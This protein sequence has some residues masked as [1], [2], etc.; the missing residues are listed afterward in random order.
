LTVEAPAALIGGDRNTLE[1]TTGARFPEPLT[2]PQEIADAL[3][4]MRDALLADPASG[5]WGPFLIV[6]RSTGEAAGSAGFMVRPDDAGTIVL[7][8]SVYPS[9]QRRGIAT[10]AAQAF[11]SWALAQ[12]GIRRL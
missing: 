2:A 11:V 5:R 9:L 12:P 4:A 3:P 6:L 10:E 7:G 8:Y 1:A